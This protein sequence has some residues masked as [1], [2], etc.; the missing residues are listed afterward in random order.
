MDKPRTEKLFV[1]VSKENREWVD[2]QMGKRGERNATLF[3]DELLTF[4]RE[5]EAEMIALFDSK[6]KPTRPIHSTQQ[7]EHAEEE[8][9]IPK[10][11]RATGASAA[12]RMVG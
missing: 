2:A 3:V 9:N 7:V 12:R 5:N 8:R 1:R 6:H 11:A 4:C 10:R